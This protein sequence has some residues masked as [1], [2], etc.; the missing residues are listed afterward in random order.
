MNTCPVYR[1]SGGH[2]YGSVIPGPIGSILAP[3]HQMKEKQDLPFASSLCGS[4]SNV[5]P[6]KVDIHNQIYR[7]RQ[8]ISEKKIL[9][10]MKRLTLNI[11]GKVLSRDC[12]YNFS[13][14][15]TRW[16]L[17]NLPRKLFYNKAS[18]WGWSR[19]LPEA[20]KKSFKEWYKKQ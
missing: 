13:G 8:E 2:S 15:V 16:S 20:P 11:A 4:C 12:M 17:R 18:T 3:I 10:K 5:C 7:W 9:P 19:E 1:R 6:V 14:K